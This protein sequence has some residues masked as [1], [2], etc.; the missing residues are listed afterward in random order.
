[1]SGI[2]MPELL[3]IFF[4]LGPIFVFIVFISKAERQLKKDNDTIIRE[5]KSIINELLERQKPQETSLFTT[6]DHTIP[7]F[8]ID[9][10]SRA[11]Y[12]LS[13]PSRILY[14]S[15]L[16]W[17]TPFTSKLLAK[18]V[19]CNCCFCHSDKGCSLGYFCK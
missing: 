11:P 7:P 6:S 17:G 18:W 5:V 4:I 3:V 14:T 12:R 10:S 19:C 8:A 13:S 16:A 2:G 15:P 9:E 1:M